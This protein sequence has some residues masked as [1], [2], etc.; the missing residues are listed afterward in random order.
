MSRAQVSAARAKE[1]QPEAFCPHPR[2]L[3]RTGDGSRCPR[4]PA[5]RVL[6]P[7]ELVYRRAVEHGRIVAGY[8]PRGIRIGLRLDYRR[9]ARAW[10]DVKPMRAH[11]LGVA[12]GIGP[13]FLP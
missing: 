2:C 1:L 7:H 3:W 13:M 5:P 12:R 8:A 11:L 6:E 9:N 10:R 4:H